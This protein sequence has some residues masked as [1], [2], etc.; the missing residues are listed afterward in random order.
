MAATFSC[1]L[2]E[3]KS[4][5]ALIRLANLRRGNDE[6]QNPFVSR[7]VFFVTIEAETAINVL[8]R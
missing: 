2:V 8:V 5:A 7:T 4:N 6:A 1:L 3:D